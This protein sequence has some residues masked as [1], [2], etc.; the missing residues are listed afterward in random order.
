MEGPHP[1]S[2]AGPQTASTPTGPAAEGARGRRGDVIVGAAVVVASLAWF[3]WRI[4]RPFPWEDEGAT[5]IVMSRSWPQFLT[6]WHGADAP[7][8]PYYLLTRLWLGLLHLILGTPLSMGPI[9]SLSAVAAALAVGCVYAVSA[10]WR[11][12]WAGLLAAL[13]FAFFPGVS[14][15]AQEARPYAL[16]MFGTTLS[17]L[18][19]DVWRARARDAA[20]RGGWARGIGY[21]VVLAG[22]SLVHLF[23]LFQWPAQ[24]VSTWLVEGG[25]GQDRR[26][27]WRMS[28]RAAM[29]MVLALLLAAYPVAVAAS[30]GKGGWGPLPVTI[31]TVLRELVTVVFYTTH[32]PAWAL[33]VLVVLGLAGLS[34]LLP[35]GGS[36]AASERRAFALVVVIWFAIPFVL[37]VLAG[38]AIKPALMQTRYWMPLAP[39]LAILTAMGLLRLA[40][41]ATGALRRGGSA[42]RGGVLPIVSF[43]LAVVVLAPLMWS[44]NLSTRGP[45]GHGRNP[46]GVLKVVQ[47]TRATYPGTPVCI[48]PYTIDASFAPVTPD[49]VA[50]NPLLRLHSGSATVWP[51]AQSRAAVATSLQHAPRVLVIFG[52]HSAHTDP[53]PSVLV[54]LGYRTVWRKS[55]WSGYSV[56]LLQK[57]S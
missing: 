29:F 54:S 3:L 35:V 47:Q 46:T 17:W 36:P 19:W 18:A 28:L 42:A 41:L 7:L 38:L 44:D 16:L 15:Y 14:R 45:G 50:Q 24:L 6:V 4:S 32:V 56:L 27:R 53:A 21:S 9:R 34:D 33:A 43:V 37:G 55:S 48:L 23:G 30:R 10:R 8:F 12:R 51:V 31:P 49:F 25:A 39:P 5:F 2:M 1:A 52:G 40:E 22:T 13:V 20:A 57:S 26:A 11:G